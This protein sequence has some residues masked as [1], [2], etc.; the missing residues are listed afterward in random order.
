LRAFGKSLLVHWWALMSCAAFTILG[1]VVIITQASPVWTLWATFGLAVAMLLVGSFLAWKDEHQKV[2][3]LEDR[4]RSPRFHLQSGI[5]WYVTRE[6]DNR[7]GIFVSLV[8][9]NPHGPPSGAYDWR[10]DLEFLSRTVHGEVPIPDPKDLVLPIPSQ[11]GHKI[12]FPENT[13][14]P[15]LTLSPIE[16]GGM[17]DGWLRAY[18][19]DVDNECIFTDQ[20]YMVI[21]C[22]DIVSG[23]RHSLR[24]KIGTGPR[25]VR[26]PS[27]E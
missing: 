26:L 21:S 4:L 10:M 7:F 1:V 9:M 13:Y 5:T 2:I 27:L 15:K 14:L 25:G 11:Q 22:K 17:R 23:D 19:R 16:A 6:S 20:P 8:V 12:I 24:D 3:A 18:F